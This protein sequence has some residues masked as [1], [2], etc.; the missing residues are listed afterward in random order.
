MNIDLVPE[1]R[2]L[3]PLPGAF[4]GPLDGASEGVVV[5][6]DG[7][8]AR[9]AALLLA[10]KLGGR[11]LPAARVAGKAIRLRLAETLDFAAELPSDQ[12]VEA[13]RLEVAP[14]GVELCAL[15]PEGLL[16]ASATLLQ[17]VRRKA[18]RLVLPCAMIEDWP[19]FRYRGAAD[20]LVN[21]EVN[22]WVYD[23]AD[24]MEAFRAR[25]RRKLDACFAHKINLVW[26]DG[27]GW[28]TQRFPGYAALMRDCNRYARQR[29][30]K[31]EFGGYGGGY[32][33]AYQSGEIYRCGY[34]GRVLQNRRSYPDGAVYACRGWTNYNE[35]Q[36]RLYGTCLSNAR[37]C[38]EKLDDLKRFVQ[39]VQ[40]GFLY[41]HDIDAGTWTQAEATWKNRCAAC[42]K[43]WPNDALDAVDGQAGAFA[44]WFRKVRRAVDALPERGGYAPARD[45]VINFISPLYTGHAETRPEDVWE[46]E[47]RYFECLSRE[48]GPAAGV[49]F[50]LREQYYAPDGGK[51][52]AALRWRLDR[53]GHGHGLHVAAFVGGD[54]Y[55]ND[56]LTTAAGALA[57]FY[58]GAES[59]YL[60]NG[61][62]HQAPVQLLNAAFLW[63]GAVDG[64]REEPADAPAAADLLGEFIAGRR[65]PAELFAPGAAFDRLCTR[66]WGR[67]A[68]RAMSRA[69][70]ARHEGLG[71]VTHVWWSITQSLGL[72]RRD[73][74][75]F[76]LANVFAA[77]GRATALALRF[78]RRAAAV[79]DDE[80]IR[81]FVRCLE[82]G[83]RFAAAMD[84]LF[85]LR[86]GEP[87]AGT[88]LKTVLADLKRHIRKH[89]PGPSTDALGG[90]PGCWLGTIAQIEELAR[91]CAK[92][93]PSADRLGNFQIQWRVSPVRRL[94][95][96]LETLAPPAVA[97][98]R[99]WGRRTFP[100]AFCELQKELARFSPA[101]GVVVYAGRL[102]FPG[103]GAGELRLG[104]DGP[105]KVWFD[106]RE[107]FRDPAGTNPGKVDKAV[108][109]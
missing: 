63:N 49:E 34:F 25:I 90:D 71:P 11:A 82:A 48:L 45:L 16:R 96:G 107:V 75:V 85:R 92:R 30:I 102:R 7:A 51:K 105:V 19:A 43:R 61:G 2:R 22:R 54:N 42:R 86:A 68:G 98:V 95:G 24:G 99:T 18:G 5:A 104:Y 47:M 60:S 74:E 109:P 35:G 26:F 23:W 36:S 64:F 69:L 56:D 9:A 59:V 53:V 108:I 15:T 106:G 72:L 77:R 29:G 39:A 97:E 57:H 14:D 100:T 87:A 44:D 66:L 103:R 62:L 32:G 28:G 10:E 12:C 94:E 81:W 13:Y 88:R 80:E 40:P 79:S 89:F 17:M 101:E 55:F 20:W 3:K 91:G 6:Y 8:A 33:T 46:R 4:V 1:P 93:A 73:D 31:L 52:I 58:E 76:P 38:R 70:Q 83:G 27:F 21:V 50:G 65:K 67:A 78:A 37:L 41:I 84:C